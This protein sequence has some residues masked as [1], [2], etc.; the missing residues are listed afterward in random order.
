MIK[1]ASFRNFAS[2]MSDMC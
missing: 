2:L 1:A